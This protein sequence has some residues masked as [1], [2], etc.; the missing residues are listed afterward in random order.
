MTRC[1]VCLLSDWCWAALWL[2][3]SLNFVIYCPRHRVFPS[4]C[5]CC[6]PPDPFVQI[7]FPYV[8][9]WREHSKEEDSQCLK[10]HRI[11]IPIL[12]FLPFLDWSKKF[13]KQSYNSSNEMKFR[14]KG[15]LTQK[16][17]KLV[18]FIK[19]SRFDVKIRESNEKIF[20]RDFQTPWMILV[21]K[22]SQ[23]I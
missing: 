2:A 15:N 21:K 23:P 7:Q 13:R 16:L 12:P 11:K 9:L 17:A 4:L 8:R 1:H 10:N 18:E 20:R 19:Q 6:Q 5:C 3:R 14:K 22:S